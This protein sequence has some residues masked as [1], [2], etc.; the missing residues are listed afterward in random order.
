MLK[1]EKPKH[2]TS[3]IQPKKK[4]SATPGTSEQE[5]SN[6]C[7]T[8]NHKDGCALS[9]GNTAILYCEE[10]DNSTSQDQVKKPDVSNE[11]NTINYEPHL[12][13]CANC[14]HKNTC[15]LS[16]MEGGVWHC[17]EYA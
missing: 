11:E 9:S 6:L 8:C 5:I 17:E 4:S 3:R 16:K 15:S 7:S 12:G 13:L 10:F 1:T 2:K 14:V